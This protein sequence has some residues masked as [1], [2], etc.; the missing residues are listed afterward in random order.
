VH[1]AL[2]KKHTNNNEYPGSEI[3]L[4]PQEASTTK[5]ITQAHGFV[6]LDA[7]VPNVG[8]P[9]QDSGKWRPTCKAQ[10]KWIDW[11]RNEV[12][13]PLHG[14]DDRDVNKQAQYKEDRGE[15]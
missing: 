4:A 6:G 10:E 7:I 8:E 2:V 3:F 15:D 1:F 9:S 13:C 5:I 14:A 12:G 11:N